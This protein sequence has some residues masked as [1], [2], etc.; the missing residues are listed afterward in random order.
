MGAKAQ[1][2]R[3]VDAAHRPCSVQWWWEAKTKTAIID[4]ANVIGLAMLPR[5]KFHPFKL[6][7]FGLGA[8]VRAARSRGA[9]RCWVGIG[10]S[11]TN[12]GG[13]G[14]ARALGWKF[15][16][17]EGEEIMEWTALDKLATLRAPKERRPFAELI[18]AVDVQNPL[19]GKLGCTRIYGPQKGL[20]PHDFPQAEKCLRR[21]ARVAGGDVAR[22]PGSGA[23]GG[24][25]FGL[26]YF[27]G[28]KWR[29]GFALFA[30][31]ADLE[32]RLAKVDLVVTGEGSIDQSSMM[33]KGVGEL[34]KLCRKRKI[35]CIG[36]AGVTDK[37]GGFAECHA[38]T[39]LT[40]S[41]AARKRAGY[42]LERLAE[43]VARGWEE[44]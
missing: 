9:K 25:G 6:D 2:L 24:L 14:M 26:K 20:K 33:G 39:E 10:G 3:T 32:R 44:D 36:L 19:L 8:V 42:W 34:V 38:L 43:K 18:V 17:S 12:D 23:A 7:T 4:S 21:L 22:Q 11:A 16:D 30:A 37:P 31:A 28:A 40:T 29:P 1:R 13:F 15:L 41:G 5:G 27:L 35:P